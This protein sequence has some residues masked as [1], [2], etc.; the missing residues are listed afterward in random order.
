M[1]KLEDY[2]P[3]ELKELLPPQ[4]VAREF[5]LNS[6]TL[7]YMRECSRDDGKLRGPMFLK[8]ENIILYQRRHVVIWLQ[9]TMFSPTETEQSTESA[10]RGKSKKSKTSLSSVK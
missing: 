5:G 1:R 7:S 4:K 2:S 6:D 9:K 3:R 10:K 8:D